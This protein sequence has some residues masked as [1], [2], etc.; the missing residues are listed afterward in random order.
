MMRNGSLVLVGALVLA[1]IANA[2]PVTPA[3]DAE[4]VKW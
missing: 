1:S 4:Y 3:N 2:Q